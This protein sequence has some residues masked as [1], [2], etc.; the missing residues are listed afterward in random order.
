[1]EAVDYDINVFNGGRYA[2]DKS[3]YARFYTQPV[4]DDA[5]SAEAGRPIFRDVVFIEIRA[6]GNQNNII[7]RKATREDMGRFARQYEL[8]KQGD[9][10]QVVGT[11]LTEVPWLTRSQVEELAYLRIRS[12][13]ALASL[14]DE[15]CS[16]YAGMYDLKRK[17]AAALEAAEKAAPMTA[18]A[19]ENKQL[20]GELEVLK[21][22][23]N[24]L[25]AASKKAAK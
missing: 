11:P 19:E 6:A 23:M 13:E 3:V 9:G 5:A 17:A 10:E 14:S 16:K 21:Q 22:Q 1:M 24:E 2:A 20:K 15:T 7:K 18:L 12:L 8:F 4:Q 25:I